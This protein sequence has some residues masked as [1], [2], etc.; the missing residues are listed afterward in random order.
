MIECRMPE[1]RDEIRRAAS[2]EQRQKAQRLPRRLEREDDGREHGV[3]RAREDGRHADERRDPRVDAQ[4]R[5]RPH[6]YAPTSA[7]TPPPIVKSGASVPPDVPL[8]S[9]TIH[10]TSLSADEDQQRSARERTG[11]HLLDVLVSDAEGARRERAD[12]AHD[13]R[14]ECRPPHPVDR[15]TLERILHSVQPARHEDGDD[16]DGGA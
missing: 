15:Q 6:Q 5:Y 7:P 13:D 14:T 2:R 11:K 12:D 3:R 8:P 1:Q 16:S 10:D 4:S 9:A